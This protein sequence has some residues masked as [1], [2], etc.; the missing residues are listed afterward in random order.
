M[1]RLS[2]KRRS[3]HLD[4]YE[5]VGERPFAGSQSA[6]VRVDELRTFQKPVAASIHSN[7]AAGKGGGGS[8]R[9]HPWTLEKIVWLSHAL[10]RAYATLDT[11]RS[12]GD[13]LFLA[14]TVLDDRCQLRRSQ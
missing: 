6:S 14:I 1:V 13:G 3:P 9:W 8:A 12:S 10:T 5:K 4:W 7:D 2:C 11:F